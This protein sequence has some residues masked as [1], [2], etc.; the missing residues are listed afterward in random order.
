M[1]KADKSGATLIF[2]YDTVVNTIKSEIS[3]ECKYTQRNWSQR[4]LDQQ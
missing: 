4:K 1:T 2:D 3:D